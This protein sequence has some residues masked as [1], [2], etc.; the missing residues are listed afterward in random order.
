MRVIQ[1]IS[2][3]NPIILGNVPLFNAS[4][5]I[6]E[7]ERIAMA[8]RDPALLST[9]TVEL[10]IPSPA[11]E[12]EIVSVSSFLSFVLFVMWNIKVS[13]IYKKALS[14]PSTAGTNGVPL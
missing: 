6:R 1:Y 9:H 13:N 8:S 10:E 4:R 14:G 3:M 2:K 7:V 12:V 11:V 5:M